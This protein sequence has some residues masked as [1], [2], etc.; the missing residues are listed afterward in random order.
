MS[1]KHTVTEVV[2]TEQVPQ[3]TTSTQLLVDAL[4]KDLRGRG[5][6]SGEWDS[7]DHE[8][9]SEILDAWRKIVAPYVR[10]DL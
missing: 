2:D 1:E 9:E 3:G 6:F 10:G 4:V 8:T 5:G 7:L